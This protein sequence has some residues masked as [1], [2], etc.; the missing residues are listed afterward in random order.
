MWLGS[1]R[2]FLIVLR[3]TAVLMLR[4]MFGFD[5]AFGHMHLSFVEGTL[6]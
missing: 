3:R 6:C 4:P 2:G 5:I 1:N